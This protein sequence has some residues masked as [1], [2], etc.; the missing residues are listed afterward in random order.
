MRLFQDSHRRTALYLG[1]SCGGGHSAV[2]I[3]SSAMASEHAGIGSP[4]IRDRRGPILRHDTNVKIHQPFAADGCAGRTHA[5]S[6]VAHRAAEPGI[7]VLC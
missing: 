7:D 3:V 4:A 2:R 6:G 5:M 1:R